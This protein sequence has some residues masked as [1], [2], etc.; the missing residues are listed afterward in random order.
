MARAFEGRSPLSI[1]SPKRVRTERECE[2][3]RVRE[4]ARTK[5][6]KEARRKAV[7]SSS[8]PQWVSVAEYKQQTGLS[9]ATIHRA[10][11]AGE[12]ESTK[13]RGRRLLRPPAAE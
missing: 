3:R 11:A 1:S 6:E 12:I 9:R 8:P 10:I 4:R 7:T 2:E 13:I 5:R